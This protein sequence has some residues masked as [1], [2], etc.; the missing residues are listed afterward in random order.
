MSRSFPS[1]DLI[2]AF[3]AVMRHGSLSGAA[4]SLQTSQPTVRRH[5]EGLEDTLGQPLFT[6]AA[7]GLTPTPMAHTLLPRAQAVMAEAAALQR[8]ASGGEAELSGSVRIT[9]SRVV[10]SHVMPHALLALRQSAPKITIELAATDVAENLLHRAADIAVRFSP[11]QQLAL[12]AKRLPDVEIGLFATAQV[13][14]LSPDFVALPFVTDE[15]DDQIR[16]WLHGAGITPP[17]QTVLRCD[18]A[19]A[20]IGHIAAG[21]GVGACQVKLATRL[22]LQRILPQLK[23]QMHG[24]LVVHE[25]QAQIPRIRHIFDHLTTTLPHLM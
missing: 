9:C 23:Y 18:D 3:C 1:L 10:A 11:P 14:A 5:I 19:L 13:A 15:S 7:N 16:D 21:V 12:V 24:W 6:R 20:Q 17:R 25:D 2:P 4:R 8:A 22:G